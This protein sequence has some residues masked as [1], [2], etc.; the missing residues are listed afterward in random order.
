MLFFMAPI[1]A[2]RADV[3]AITDAFVF[4]T[5]R[6]YAILR[7]SDRLAI[8]DDTLRALSAFARRDSLE[9][10][11][12]YQHLLAWAQEVRRA[13]KAA[14]LAP[15]IDGLGPLLYPFD[16]VV[17]PLNVDGPAATQADR[18]LLVQLQGLQGRDFVDAYASSQSAALARLDRAYVDYIQN[19]DDPELRRLSVLNLPKVRAL[20]AQLRRF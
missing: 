6:D 15:T 9:Q 16:A 19:G 5:S 18:A 7:Q 2:A 10:Y 11:D 14:A 12:A 17:Q 13:A 20:L 3:A 1:T 8:A 4:E